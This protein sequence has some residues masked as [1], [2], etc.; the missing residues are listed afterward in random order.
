M[1]KNNTKDKFKKAIK[2]LMDR[3]DKKAKR[4]VQEAIYLDSRYVAY[5][6]LL[7]EFDFDFKTISIDE[8]IFDDIQELLKGYPRKV[9][10]SLLDEVYMMV[11]KQE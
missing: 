8:N 1:Q 10:L 7:K 9:Q 2:C 3:D 6:K 4:I 5:K 11:A